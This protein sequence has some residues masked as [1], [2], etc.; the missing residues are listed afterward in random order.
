MLKDWEF[1]NQ[2]MPTYANSDVQDT[3]PLIGQ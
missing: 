1:N 2:Q 3:L